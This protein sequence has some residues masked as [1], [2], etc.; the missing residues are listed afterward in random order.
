[1]I[2]NEQQVKELVEWVAEKIRYADTNENPVLIPDSLRAD[3]LKAAKIIL[4]HPDLAL[5]D[6]ERAR[7][8]F[9]WGISPI[10]GYYPIIPLAEAIKEVK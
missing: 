8:D 10:K 3:Y 2:T 1:M 4:S 9:E 6:R 7:S 5:I